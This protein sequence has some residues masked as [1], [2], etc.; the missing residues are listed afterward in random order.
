M[1]VCVSQGVVVT[2]DL[3]ALDISIDLAVSFN[4]LNVPL[5]LA[6]G[7]DVVVSSRSLLWGNFWHFSKGC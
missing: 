1:C 6:A 3:V 4:K 7:D 5:Q 2:N